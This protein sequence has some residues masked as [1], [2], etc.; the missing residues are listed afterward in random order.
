MKGGTIFHEPKKATSRTQSVFDVAFLL[1]CVSMSTRDAT[2]A[3][4][5]RLIHCNDGYDRLAGN[6]QKKGVQSI[7]GGYGFVHKQGSVILL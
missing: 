4:S 1:L 7:E 6:T 3:T 2:P 5:K